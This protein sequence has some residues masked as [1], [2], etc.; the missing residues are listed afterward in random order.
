MRWKRCFLASD[1]IRGERQSKIA[2]YEK[3][4]FIAFEVELRNLVG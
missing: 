3:L 1:R 4:G 2:G